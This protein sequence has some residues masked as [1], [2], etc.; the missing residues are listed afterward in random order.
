MAGQVPYFGDYAAEWLRMHPVAEKT[1]EDYRWLLEQ[2]LQSAFGNLRLDQITYRDV[3]GWVMET[4]PHA[5]H[6]V[7]QALSIVRQVYRLA[8]IEGYVTASPAKLVK[9]PPATRALPDPL[10]PDEIQ[11][12]AQQLSG[13]DLLIFEVLVYGG[14]RFSEVTALKPSSVHGDYVLVAGGLIPARGGGWL[15]SDGKTHQRRR[16]YLPPFVMERLQAFAAQCQTEL[17]FTSSV[18]TPVHRTNWTSRSLQPACDRAGVRK[19]TPHALRDTCATLALRSGIAPQVVAAHLGHADATTTLRH[20]AGVVAGDLEHLSVSL[21]D[22]VGAVVP[23]PGLEP[24]TKG[25]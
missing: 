3:Q 12:V 8:E 10:S 25:L 23:P 24:G 4:A 2:Y 18:G 22:A 1:A 21:Q 5:Y 19:I 6:Q 16:V 20:Y 11:R 15:H 14:L 7:R 13:R 17:L 9:M